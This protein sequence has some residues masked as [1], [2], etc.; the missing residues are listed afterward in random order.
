MRE[1]IAAQ[2]RDTVHW[3]NNR[4]AGTFGVDDKTVA[5]IRSKLESSGAIP[6]V[7]DR[8]GANGKA[9]PAWQMRSV[10]FGEEGAGF[11][12]RCWMP[13][14]P[15]RIIRAWGRFSTEHATDALAE[16]VRRLHELE[17]REDRHQAHTRRELID[18]RSYQFSG[19]ASAGERHAAN[20]RRQQDEERSAADR[21]VKEHAL[22][23]N[24]RR[25]ADRT[26]AGKIAFK[27]GNAE[28]FER[29]AREATAGASRE[30]A[31]SNGNASAALLRS[32]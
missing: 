8:E 24:A 3:S 31:A 21:R 13:A 26:S 12:R 30:I 16:I 25:F 20:L 23:E 4:I 9:R 14:A 11:R 19:Y 29:A 10:W 15:K 5:A 22:N 7:K 27:Y 32:D 18:M 28:A 1:Q 2:L 17:Q 6:Y